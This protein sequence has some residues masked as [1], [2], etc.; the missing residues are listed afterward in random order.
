MGFVFSKV[1]LLLFGGVCLRGI[2]LMTT[3]CA[4]L[5][6]DELSDMRDGGGGSASSSGGL[7][8]G[9]IVSG[10]QFGESND[11]L[12]QGAALDAQG[13]V[14]MTGMNLG[15]T[16]MQDL[17]CS[18]ASKGGLD[19]FATWVDP[20]NLEV[21]CPMSRLLGSDG[22]DVPLG[23]AANPKLGGVGIV[24]F[25]T[26]NF[27]CGKGS[28]TNHGGR[29]VVVTEFVGNTCSWQQ[30]FGGLDDQEGQAIAFDSEG[31]AYIGGRFK[32]TLE[33]EQPDNNVATGF[34]AFIAK[35][36]FGTG[37]PASSKRAGGA[38][39]QEVHTIA[40]PS[41]NTLIVGGRFSETLDFQCAEPLSTQEAG[42]DALFVASLNADMKACNWQ[43]KIA[44]GPQ[45]NSIMAL[46][47]A[48]DGDIFVAGGFQSRTLFPDPS[49]DQ[50][51]CKL[52]NLT[53]AEDV[54]VAKLNINGQ[55]Q[56]SRRFGEV[57]PTFAEQQRAYAIA[58]DSAS[59]V[60]VTGQFHGSIAFDATHQYQSVGEMDAFV[61]KLNS[62]G[63]Y[64]WSNVIAGAGN[65]AGNAVVLDAS[66]KFVFVAGFFKDSSLNLAGESLSPTSVDVFL[67][68]LIR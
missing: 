19:M 23:I 63:D 31:A 33:F 66:G 41:E 68:K 52:D 34:D 20:N 36:S 58:V 3:G 6:F 26:G 42:H 9:A 39:D 51:K 8:G 4:S 47:V 25:S 18:V 53:Q 10:A 61:L 14:V 49:P 5:V 27:D 21:A 54:F 35:L 46:A 24:G 67:A 1:R 28:L 62:A 45:E 29:D 59:N 16:M 32:G 43:K 7:E 57:N 17:G 48:N 64:V 56:W 44:Q 22:S 30:S 13:R 11:Q 2:I 37:A 12:V 38:G 55:C 15:N 50:A 40:I 60:Y 65:E